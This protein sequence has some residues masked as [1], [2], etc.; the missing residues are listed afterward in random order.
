MSK[1]LKERGELAIFI[2]EKNVPGRRDRRC[3]GSEAVVCPAC[4]GNSRTASVAEV[5]CGGGGGVM[6]GW[7][8]RE[9]RDIKT[10]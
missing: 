10:L 3:K 5:V 9:I 6:C 4:S 8:R 1:D 7:W 2:W